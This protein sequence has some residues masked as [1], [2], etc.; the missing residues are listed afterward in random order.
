MGAVTA[1][2]LAAEGHEIVG[3][4][5]DESK[6]EQINRGMTPILE[7]R[8]DILV[9]E[10]VH[11]G[12]LRASLSL[13]DSL[14]EAEMVMICVGTPS[15]PG[16][17]LD[18][19]YLLKVIQQIGTNLKSRREEL[20]VVVRSTVLPG[21]LSEVVLPMLE[22]TTA[23]I[24]NDGYNVVFHPEFLREGTAVADFYSPPKI[25]VGERVPGAGNAVLELYG[26]HIPAPRITC[27]LEEAEMVKYC[28]NMFHAVKVTFANEVGIMCDALGIDGSAVMNIFCMDRKLNISDKYLM[29][30]FAFG[31]S[32]LPKDL[33]A[34]LALARRERIQLPMLE[35][36]LPSNQMQSER[37]ITAILATGAAKIGFHGL[38][39]K[40]GTDDLRESP[41][42]T[43]AERLIGKGRSLVIFDRLVETARLIGRNKTYVENKLPHLA[44]L[45]T[46]DISKLEDCDLILLCHH[47]DAGLYMSWQ[48]DGRAM[49][50]LTGI[51]RK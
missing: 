2:C 46:D 16:G 31:G 40:E 21:L 20:L 35:A 38:A 8:L 10:G 30:G 14:K 29:P 51:K 7:E 28:D 9:A 42:V 12:R 24:L 48:K 44:R 11:Q 25:V 49:M 34:F 3:V 27:S 5:V 33:R 39:F 15:L 6:V 22:S 23:S 45:L 50:D 43:V 47:P 41:Y 26:A 17:E 32:C 37:A 18:A 13:D 4:D 1:A 19:T 36:V